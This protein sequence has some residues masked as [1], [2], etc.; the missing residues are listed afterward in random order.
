M[1]AALVMP[2]SLG[3]EASI[4]TPPHHGVKQELKAWVGFGELG[5][6]L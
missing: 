5:C 6:V 2:L 4:I 1:E 3:D